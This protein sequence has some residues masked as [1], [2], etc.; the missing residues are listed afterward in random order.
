MKTLQTIVAIEQPSLL[1]NRLCK[2]FRHKVPAEWDEH[3]GRVEFKPGLC[4]L[5]AEG[6]RLHILLEAE[7][8]SAL[9]SLKMILD[10]HIQRMARKE[11]LELTWESA[12]T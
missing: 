10:I 1:L 8:D 5:T 12:P 4:L 7:T 6:N 3:Q 11:E 2:H 9:E